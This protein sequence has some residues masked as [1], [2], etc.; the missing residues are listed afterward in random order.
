M[1]LLRSIGYT[2]AVGAFLAIS[3]VGCGSSKPPAP[4]P[5]AGAQTQESTPPTIEFGTAISD[6]AGKAAAKK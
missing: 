3:A 6:S 2:L 4:P 5:E 1:V